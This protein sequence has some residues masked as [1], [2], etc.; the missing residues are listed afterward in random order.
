MLRHEVFPLPFMECGILASPCG[1][2]SSMCTI[3]LLA[4]SKLSLTNLFPLFCAKAL[5][6]HTKTVIAPNNSSLFFFQIRK[7]SL[8][9]ILHNLVNIDLV[10]MAKTILCEG[11]N[12]NSVF[13]NCTKMSE[14]SIQKI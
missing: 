7:M 1:I 8:Y 9:F 14:Q 13:Y 3:C 11:K 2:F 12:R 4:K 5:L 10:I 6:E